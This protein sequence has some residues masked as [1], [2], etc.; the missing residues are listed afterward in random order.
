MQCPRCGGS[1][2]QAGGPCPA[3][4]WSDERQV[5]QAPVPV[6]TDRATGPGEVAFPDP[7][8]SPAT[9]APEVPVPYPDTDR[10]TDHGTSST[11]VV[12]GEAMPPSSDL[13]PSEGD[14]SGTAGPG[15]SVG[16]L[17]G[18]ANPLLVAGIF[19]VVVVVVATIYLLAG[20]GNG[21]PNGHEGPGPD[22]GLLI[23]PIETSVVN[24]WEP[25][26]GFHLDVGILNNA[27]GSRSLDGHDLLVTV[28]VGTEEVGRATVAVSGDLAPGHDRGVLIDVAVD[29]TS[30]QM[31]E[32]NVLLRKDGGSTTVDVYHTEVTIQQS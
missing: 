28:L 9:P 10:M 2:P 8:K 27:N 31:Y 16:G 5:Q 20:D 24:V 14:E 26:P 1:L 32:V 7:C 13:P 30:G 4:A 6:A 12:G 21:G 15:W 3:C 17:P 25:T 18:S 23:D 19:V 11:K 29:L 22:G